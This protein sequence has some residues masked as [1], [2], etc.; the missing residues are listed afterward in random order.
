MNVTKGDKLI[1]IKEFNKLKEIG[2][3][4]EVADITEQF[5]VIRDSTTKIALA[6]VEIDRLDEYFKKPNDF[7]GWTEWQS[8]V[9]GNSVLFYRTNQKKVQVRNPEGVRAEAS[10]NKDDKFDLFLGLRIAHERLLI[11]IFRKTEKTLESELTVVRNEI[12]DSQSRIKKLIQSV[13]ERNDENGEN[14]S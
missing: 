13:R 7:N 12:S 2:E 11:K 9:S 14:I 8:F 1:L 3:T 5:F 10:C 4:Y 6:A